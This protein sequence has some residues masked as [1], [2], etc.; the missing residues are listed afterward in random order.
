MNQSG[1]VYQ[2]QF[3]KFFRTVASYFSACGDP[4]MNQIKVV[5]VFFLFC[6]LFFCFFVFLFFCFFV[7]LFFCF[8][9]FC[10]FVFVVLFLLFFFVFV[11]VLLFY[12]LLIYLIC[13]SEQL[14]LLRN[15]SRNQADA[16]LLL[17]RH[18]HWFSSFSF[19]FLFLFPLSFLSLFFH[20]LFLLNS[21][22]QINKELSQHLTPRLFQ[23]Y[24]VNEVANA[25]TFLMFR[26]F[27]CLGP[28]ELHDGAWQVFFMI[29]YY[30]YYL[31]LLLFI[32]IIIIYYFLLLFFIF[33]GFL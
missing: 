1:A 12:S 9:V 5:V 20:S 21:F 22:C 23:K 19:L 3:P 33:G 32:I 30:Y 16:S 28:S 26:V 8:F 4:K 2:R 6:F 17:L 27:K 13:Y 18:L 7:F 10:C 29:I 15:K 24:S 14:T 25:V 31:L 11:F